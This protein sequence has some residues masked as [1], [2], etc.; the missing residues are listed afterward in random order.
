MPRSV[1]VPSQGSTRI[2]AQNNVAGSID[3]QHVSVGIDGAEVGGLGGDRLD[4]VRPIQVGA[5]H[6]AEGPH[7]LTLH[8]RAKDRADAEV[9]VLNTSQRFHVGREP[10][11]VVA[12]VTAPDGKR[13]HVE[14]S[15][16]GATLDGED[17]A[18][19]SCHGLPPEQADI[20]AIEAMLRNAIAD[21]DAPRVVCIDACLARMHELARF[22]T[23]GPDIIA[24]GQERAVSKSVSFEIA[25]FAER[26]RRCP[27]GEAM[28]DVTQD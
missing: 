2:L 18:T 8:A 4:S 28:S 27:S 14:F 10:A 15:A 12:R 19:D 3:L 9:I 17:P 13:L 23:A 16:E 22:A 7:T 11:S 24:T 5:A 26:A 6:L 20:C 1:P 25:E 21:R